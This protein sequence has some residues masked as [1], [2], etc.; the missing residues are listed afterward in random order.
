MAANASI[1]DNS[2]RPAKSPVFAGEQ[3][4]CAGCGVATL[5]IS[6]Y[7][8]GVTTG[9]MAI[10]ILKGEADISQMPIEYAPQ[11]TKMYNR[12]ICDDL[13]LTPPEG[14]TPIPTE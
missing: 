3:G 14:Y 13:G 8:L 1:V 5:S 9:Q 7:D 2:C 11:F 10:K 12:A 4:I 6:Y